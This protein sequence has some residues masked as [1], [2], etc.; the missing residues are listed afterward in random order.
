M[1]TRLNQAK[2]TLKKWKRD[3]VKNLFVKSEKLLDAILKGFKV[4]RQLELS[5]CMKLKNLELQSVNI[6]WFLN[7]RRFYGS[8]SLC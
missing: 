8:R 5:I 3:N 2:A 6:I 7:N 1:R 4:R